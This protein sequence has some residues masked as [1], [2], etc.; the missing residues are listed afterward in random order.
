MFDLVTLVEQ[1]LGQ[2]KRSGAW[3]FW[4]CPF[5]AGDDTPSLAVKDDRYYCFACRASGDAVDWL[6]EY[7][8]MSKGDALRLVRGENRQPV[9][10]RRQPEA[11]PEPPKTPDE[12]WQARA[13]IW[14]DECHQALFEPQGER[15]FNYLVERRGLAVETIE[16]FSLGYWRGGETP[17]GFVRRGITI[18]NFDRAGTL[19][20]VKLRH[21]EG[22]P[23]YTGLTGSVQRMFEA[24]TIVPGGDVV[25]CEG[26]FDALIAWQ[27]IRDVCGVA[28]FGGCS[29]QPN[30]LDLLRL[31]VAA[32]VVIAYDNDPAG[33]EAA[34]RL[35]KLLPK[36]VICRLP[37]GVK[38]LNEAFQRGQ[39][40]YRL[41]KPCLSPAP[42][43]IQEW[44]A[45]V[46]AVVTEE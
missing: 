3:L 31:L 7:R 44:A 26:E 14:A 32:R 30:G 16:R 1:D 35:A 38:D 6:T 2:P 41:V 28:A 20:G 5:H 45:S 15:A 29:V 33:Q 46:G 19:Y 8:R 23:K 25:L 37:D 42:G 17:F 34:G 24:A 4:R 10:P 27:T 43:S 21:P 13:A 22:Q 9:K 12:E 36:A 18:P 40:I 39:D 11:Q